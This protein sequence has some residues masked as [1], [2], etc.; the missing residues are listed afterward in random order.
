MKPLM[1]CKFMKIFNLHIRRLNRL[2]EKSGGVAGGHDVDF[3][4]YF[5]ELHAVALQNIVK[6][7]YF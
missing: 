3:L 7:Y 2:I 6:I 5:Y 4:L 1:I